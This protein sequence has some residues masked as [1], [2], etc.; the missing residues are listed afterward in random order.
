M[1]FAVSQP[2]QRAAWQRDASILVVD[3]EVSIQ[4]LLAAMLQSE[5]Y[6]V[7]AVGSA[8]EA[9]AALKSAPASLLITDVKL[10]DRDGIGLL[11]QACDL[12]RRMIGVVMTGYASIDIAVQA[13]KAGAAEFLMK[14]FHN[15][16]VLLTVKRLLEFYRLRV[17]NAVLKQAV[18]RA[19]G[20]RL[21]DLALTDFGT[22]KQFLGAGGPSD[23]D[24]GVA[25]GERRAGARDAIVQRRE[26]TLFADA[27]HQL[28][29]VWRS[30][31]QTM[32]ADVTALAFS[33]ATRILR[34]TIAERQDAVTAQLKAA[35]ATIRESGVVTVRT[36]P[37]D[38]SVLEAAR[39]ELIRDRE[40][41]VALHIEGD[42]SL[43]RGSC[44]VQT[45]N[46]L[47]DASLDQQLLRL[48]EVLQ[49]R[50]RGAAR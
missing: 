7:R 38:V 18:V 39:P 21:Q 30:L 14:P 36:H 40:P 37:S 5:G 23:Y 42:A 31:S 45:T 2:A 46:R 11:Q 32:E 24:L 13:M 12:D 47:V 29:E 8:S 16:V 48:G 49:K 41:G 1:E 35:L 10:P 15:D 6:R 25:E 28:D 43:P 20:V 4:E 17:E 22:G 9:L 44:V 26:R 50:G 19:G 27:V 33:L 3:D 34:D